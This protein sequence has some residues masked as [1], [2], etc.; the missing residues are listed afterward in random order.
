MLKVIVIGLGYVGLPI[1]LSFAKKYETYGFDIDSNKIANYKKG[2]DINN[3]FSYKE[4]R[5]TKIKF[6]TNPKDINKVDFVI[7]TVPTPIDSRNNPDLSYLKNAT[8]LVAKNMKEGA[9]VIY[10][11]TV[12]P[13]TTEE[14]CVPIIEK[15]SK[16]K[17]NENFFVGYSPERINPGD[18]KHEFENIVKIV[19][20]SSQNTVNNIAK[21]YQKCLKNKVVKVSSIKVAEASKIIEN[22]QR[23]INIA[24]INEISKIFH[25]MNIDT[26]EVLNAAKTKWNFLDFKPGLVGGH[27]IGVDP[28]YLSYESKKMGVNPEVILAGRRV[29]DS[30]AMYIVENLERIL[31][32][33]NIKLENLKVLVK[34]ITFKENISDIRNSKAVD[35]IKKLKHDGMIVYIEDYNVNEKE[36]QKEYGLTLS[37]NIPKVD[38]VIFA[39]KHNKYY[40]MTINDL[41]DLFEKEN[42]KKIVFDLH[43]IFNKE[44]LKNGGFIVWNL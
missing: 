41:S 43:S 39:V 38:V 1:A 19:S 9:T 29:N 42:R 21:L 25:S 22:S 24:F 28:Y 37:K 14:I 12:Y 4:L 36:L 16:M 7:I 11:S 3:Q 40:K 20:G 27:C 23:D 35:I 44:K 5:R 15:V 33:E 10:E 17:L 30:M 31:K 13:S 18:K 34:G 26:Q 32:K 6:T 8:E 2:I